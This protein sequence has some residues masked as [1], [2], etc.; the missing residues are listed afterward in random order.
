M[1][2]VNIHMSR[3]SLSKGIDYIVHCICHIV[4]M[5][6]SSSLKQVDT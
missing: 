1:I 2:Q 6:T 3:A 4:M 5:R